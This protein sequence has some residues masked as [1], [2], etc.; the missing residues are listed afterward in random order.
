MYT[1]PYNDIFLDHNMK[2][3]KMIEIYLKYG[4]MHTF[5]VINAFICINNHVISFISS[6][7]SQ[8]PTGIISS[9]LEIHYVISLESLII[10]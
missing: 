4:N 3:C 1:Y 7:L 10:P 8:R 2:L 9:L 5:G 6:M